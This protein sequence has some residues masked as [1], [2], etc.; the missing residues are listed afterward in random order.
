GYTE[1]I[2][3]GVT[4]DAGQRFPLRIELRGTG[5][6]EGLVR[7]ASGRGIPNAL[8]HANQ[9]FARTDAPQDEARTDSA[10]AYRLEGVTPGRGSL[11]AMRDGSALG[12]TAIA[13]VPEG[14]TGRLDFQIRDEGVLTGHLRRKDGSPPPPDATVRAMP[15]DNR[16]FRPDDGTPLSVDGAGLYVASLPAGSYLLWAQNARGGGQSRNRVLAVVEAGKTSTQ[17]LLL[18]D[19]ADDAQA[20]SG[21]VLEPDGGGSAGAMVRAAGSSGDRSLGFSVVADERGH[22]QLDRSRADLPQTFLVLAFNGGRAGQT[23]VAPGVPDV[24]IQL[25]PG[26]TVRGHLVDGPVDGFVVEARPIG[27]AGGFGGAAQ[28][29][30]FSGDRFVMSDLPAQSVR[31]VVSTRD[32]RSASQDVSLAPK[33]VRDIEVALQPMATVSGRL[34]DSASQSIIQDAFV[35]VDTLR[36]S[37]SDGTR[38]D[39]TGRFRLR[40]PAGDH[41]LHCFLPRY[42]G[43]NRAFT[44]AAGH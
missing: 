14:G 3:R 10:G 8:V 25:R 31:V 7:D 35:F 22:F 40:V 19:V 17:D 12:T 29:L 33:M 43:L 27:G 34:V 11:V 20:F 23:A 26:A 5:A 18:A 16:S 15:S 36:S 4:V 39:A 21:T 28:S 9:R 44:V 32:G 41:A 6:L 42:K 1:V 30:Q 37:Q 24:T 13:D 2:R 38:T